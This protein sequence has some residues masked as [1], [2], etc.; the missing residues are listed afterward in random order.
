MLAHRTEPVIAVVAPPGYGKTTVLAEWAARQPGEVAWVS[1]DEGDNDPSAL[2]AATAVAISRVQPIDPTVIDAVTARTTTIPTALRSLTTA[3]SPAGMTLVLDHVEAVANTDTLDMIAELVWRLP[4]GSRLA[5]ASRTPIP[6]PNPLLRSRGALV[7]IGPTDLAMNR[8][9]A[10]QLLTATGAKLTN[11]EIDVLYEQTE[12][13]PAGLYLAALASHSR[14]PA[15]AF[16]FHGDDVLMGDYLRTEIL[17]HLPTDTVT[18]LTRTSILDQLCGPLCDA[19]TGNHDSQA[20]L[21]TLDTANLMVVPLD[22]QRHWYRYHRLFRDLL[23]TELH[24]REP[25]LIPHLHH[26][27][28]LWLHQ[29]DMN[30]PAIRHAQRS[31]DAALV[32]QARRAA[33]CNL[34]M[35]PV[36]PPTPA[37]GWNGSAPTTSS[38]NT[39]TSP[40]SEHSSKHSPDAPPAPNDGPPPPKQ[41]PPT[42]RQQQLHGI[43]RLPAQPPVP[44]RT[45]TDA[46]R[47]AGR[48][49]DSCGAQSGCG[50]RPCCGGLSHLFE[51]EARS[52]RTALCTRIRSGD[53]CRRP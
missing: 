49:S 46:R 41:P 16:T 4:G 19:V 33:P 39:P 5:Y 2:L 25:D 36:E 10:Q 21:E 11:D 30:E 53:E 13:W 18:F 38:N 42:R 23:T 43:P 35:P 28:A 47:R 34:R 27:A 50:R 6:L 1:I 14:R 12:G 20:T 17:A 52:R 24:R 7:E 32:V 26:R 31:G 37:P 22:R 15:T 51:G 44:R 9:E 29:H 40:S 8:H 45:R 48:P 3:L